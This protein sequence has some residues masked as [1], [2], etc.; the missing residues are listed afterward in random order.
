MAT[1]RAHFPNDELTRLSKIKHSSQPTFR[2]SQND[3]TQTTAKRLFLGNVRT[4][5]K[6]LQFELLLWPRFEIVALLDTAG[7][8]CLEAVRSHGIFAE[9]QPRDGKHDR[10]SVC[11]FGSTLCARFGL[12]PLP[13]CH[14]VCCLNVDFGLRIPSALWLERSHFIA[15]FGTSL[16]ISVVSSSS[17]SFV[18]HPP[19]FLRLPLALSLR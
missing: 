3:G 2:E 13:S 11:A 17:R 8:T 15:R 10:V 19:V 12:R 9:L 7:L 6:D 4:G 16:F 5:G 1:A 18:S 14:P